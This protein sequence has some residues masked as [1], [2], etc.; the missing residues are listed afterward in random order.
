[1]LGEFVFDENIINHSVI[2]S[3]MVIIPTRAIYIFLGYKP[4]T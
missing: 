3:S 2:Y 4:S 1:M